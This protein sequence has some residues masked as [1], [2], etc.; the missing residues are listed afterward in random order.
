MNKNDLRYLKT[1]KII[2]ESFLRVIDKKGFDK[3]TIMDICEDAMISRNTFYV[4]YLDKYDLLDHIYLD[5]KQELIESLST[6]IIDTLKILDLYE[7]AKWCVTEAYKNREL[8][9]ILL[10]SSRS[11]FRD[12]LLEIF[13]RIPARKIFLNYDEFAYKT[14]YEIICT[15]T[16]DAMLGFFEVWFNNYQD[17]SLEHAINLMYEL[18]QQPA[19]LYMKKL[20]SDP[21]CILCEDFT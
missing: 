10:K 5:L 9:R 11:D 12:L 19:K 14:E 15:Y 16:G 18:V 6:H 2:R 7:S 4:H 20:Y 13:S 8:I 1:E 17:I 21:D 3:A